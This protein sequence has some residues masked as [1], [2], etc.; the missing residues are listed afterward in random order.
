[1]PFL[2]LSS[3]GLGDRAEGAD[4]IAAEPAGGGQL[5]DALQAAVIGEEQQALGVDVEPA[6]GEDA[7]QAFCCEL[8]EDGLA[9]LGVLL[10]DHEAGGLVIEPDAGALARSASGRAVDLDL[11]LVGDVEGGGADHLAVDGDAAVLDPALGVAARAEAGAGDDLGEPVAVGV[12][13]AGDVSVTGSGA[14]CGSRAGRPD[15]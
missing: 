4:A 3:C 14:P 13:A 6:D 10:G 12:R 1:M 9:A 8:F 5:E 15:R 11:V 2:S 7:R